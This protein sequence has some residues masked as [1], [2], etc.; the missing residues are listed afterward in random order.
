MRVLVA[1]N[2]MRGAADAP[3]AALAIRRGL[4]STPRP[5]EVV[6]LCPV[7]D[8]GDGTA[9]CIVAAAHGG[10]HSRRVQGPLGSPV[11]ARYGIVGDT[12]VIEMAAASGQRVAAKRD[13]LHASTFGTGE[14]VRDAVDRG[15]K[16]IIVGLGGSA[17]NDG[18]RGFAEALGWRFLGEAG[19]PLPPGPLALAQLARVEPG[20]PLDVELIAACDVDNPLT[21]PMGASAV[22]GPQKGAGPDAV[23]RLDA[24]LAQLAQV[25]SPAL[26]ATPGSGAAGG[27][28]FGLM[29]F[30]GARLEPG[31]ELCLRTVGFSQ[32]VRDTDL[33]I[34]AEGRV[35]AQ[36]ARGKAPLAVAR[37]AGGVPVICLT[38]SA[39]NEAALDEIYAAGITAVL[40]VAPGPITLRASIARTSEL[41]ADAAARA[42]RLFVAGRNP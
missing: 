34:T 31:A 42:W 27:L 17:T 18:G 20:P 30:A 12:A 40:P 39:P 9:E 5:P 3:S 14:L 1:P 11:D 13:P 28:G 33:V 8:G 22:F 25:V 7:A 10:W 19:E 41:L 36:T 15:F 24:A 29:A 16:R 4:L 26:A 2:A 21:G 38:G 32:R 23:K 37:A 35:D 6:D